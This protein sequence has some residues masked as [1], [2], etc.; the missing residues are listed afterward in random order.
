MTFS[1][2]DL[3]TAGHEQDGRVAG[4]AEHPWLA[5]AARTV[6][7]SA[8]IALA[9]YLLLRLAGRTVPFLLLLAVV[10][11]GFV[12]RRITRTLVPPPTLAVPVAEEVDAPAYGHPDRPFAEARRWE[13]RLHWIANH[14]DQ[15]DRAVRPA[16]ATVVDERLRLRY[17]VTRAGDPGRARE[18]LGQRLWEFLA[19]RPRPRALTAAELSAL[20]TEAEA[21]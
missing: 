13:E 5:L 2:D 8:G 20:I 9:A 1:I 14:A 3:L 12:G 6:L 7:P 4:P 15:F 17:S 19:E 16:I 11:A 21:L 18:I 10:L